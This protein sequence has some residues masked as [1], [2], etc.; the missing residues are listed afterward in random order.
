MI[1]MILRIDWYY[2]LTGMLVPVHSCSLEFKMED[3]CKWRQ[4]RFTRWTIRSKGENEQDLDLLCH[5]SR[6]LHFMVL[7]RVKRVRICQQPCQVWFWCLVCH[8][9]NQWTNDFNVCLIFLLQVFAVAAL[10]NNVLP[11]TVFA[12]SLIFAKLLLLVQKPIHFSLFAKNMTDW[13]SK[14]IFIWFW[15]QCC[16]VTVFATASGGS[17]TENSEFCLVFQLVACAA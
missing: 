13:L 4:C 3:E 11:T 15:H 9:H 16:C 14:K 12:F 10:W 7:F 5:L 17:K 8:L 6:R 1:L 2:F